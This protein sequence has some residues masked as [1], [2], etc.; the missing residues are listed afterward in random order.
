MILLTLVLLISTAACAEEAISLKANTYHVQGIDLEGSRLWVSSVDKEGRRGFLYEFG[1]PDSRLVRMVEVGQE[2]RYHPG[3][4]SLDGESLWVPVAEYKRASSAFIQRR[5]RRT[6]EIIS[7]FEA[8][9]HIGAIAVTADTIIGANWDARDFY[10]W[11]K[12]G[13]LLH[14]VPN[15]SQVAIQDMK[16][17]DGKLV[18]SGLDSRKEGAIVWFD[19][20]S[21]KILRTAPMGRSDR[22]V[23]YTHEG[24][25]IRDGRLWLLPEDNPSRLFSFPVPE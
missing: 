22:G 24:M 2:A 20:P 25:T 1:L 10:I 4:M 9:D 3:G 19:W 23:A 21:L 8:P 12:T 6:L 16:F 11:N 5:D 14:K 7:Q 17:V 15:P 18:G 13:K